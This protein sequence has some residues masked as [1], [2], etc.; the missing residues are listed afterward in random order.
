[1]E[2]VTNLHMGDGDVNYNIIDNEVEREILTNLPIMNSSGVKGSLREYFK[3]KN[4]S[5]I[6][7][8]FGGLEEN[9]DSDK[10]ANKE[11]EDSKT[12]K[13]K[14]MEPGQLK[15]FSGYCLALAMRNS[16]GNY[17]YSVVTT[18]NILEELDKRMKIFNINDSDLSF[19][20]KDIDENS[21]YHVESGVEI[22]GN[23][24]KNSFTEDNSIVSFFNKIIP[25]EL[26]HL[27][28]ITKAQM[29]D[30]DLP[31][32]ARN[33]LENSISNNLWYEEYVPHHSFF[34]TFVS[35]EDSELLDQFNQVVNNQVIQFGA[36]A[37]IG[38]GLVKMRCIGGYT[39]E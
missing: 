35:C 25:D 34:Y 9:N 14:K 5:N 38:Y 26:E 24:I 2:T 28:V 19:E 36:N 6:I 11:S 21:S 27:A 15:I 18:H 29:D 16:K 20:L 23:I 12:N 31:V 30:Y 1:M 39:N 3:K 22:E 8:L 7:Q 32:I 10:D 4:K 13:D 37:S 17:P 33:R